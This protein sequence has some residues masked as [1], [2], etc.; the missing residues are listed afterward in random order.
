VLVET[1]TKPDVTAIVSKMLLSDTLLIKIFPVP[2]PIFSLNVTTKLL[3]IE[4]PVA[5]SRGEN[6]VA[7][8][9]VTS[10]ERNVIEKS[11]RYIS[12]VPADNPFSDNKYKVHIWCD[13]IKSKPIFEGAT[14]TIGS[15]DAIP[16][17]LNV[18]S[19]PHD[20]FKRAMSYQAFRAFNKWSKEFGLRDL[21]VDS[22]TSLYEGSYKRIRAM[23]AQQLAKDMNFEG[24]SESDE[25]NSLD[26]DGVDDTDTV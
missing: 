20:P 21:P 8:G 26:C 14:Q 6:A 2:L 19:A 25:S 17:N 22:D 9:A 5:L 16:L 12:F 23:L 13:A 24:E 3:V 4:T 18:G 11:S 1:V 15:Y 7:V 10:A